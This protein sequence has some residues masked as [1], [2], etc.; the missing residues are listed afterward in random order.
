MEVSRCRGFLL[1]FGS[2]CFFPGLLRLRDAR[3]IFRGVELLF[4]HSEDFLWCS[5]AQFRRWCCV[6]VVFVVSLARIWSCRQWYRLFSFCCWLGFPVR[7]Y[8]SY[9][10]LSGLAPN[11]ILWIWFGLCCFISV[12]VCCIS[13]KP[14]K[15]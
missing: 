11:H 3:R 4:S 8:I 12:T 7:S 5:T 2:M 13:Q 1:R 15:L 9:L 14:Q 6:V 10:I